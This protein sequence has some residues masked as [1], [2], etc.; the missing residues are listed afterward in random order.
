MSLQELTIK[1][2]GSEGIRKEI[3]ANSIDIIFDVL[4]VYQYKYPI[5][6]TVRE[7]ASNAVDAQREKE[8]A[9]QILK[10]EANEEDF[11]IKKDGKEFED[12]KF[13]KEYYDL[14]WLD[15]DNNLVELNYIDG[16]GS[17]FCDKFTVTDY[18]VGIGD[19]RLE[20][21]IQLGYSTK[22]A[23]REQIGGFG[24]GGK[25]PLSTL[26]PFFT[27]ESAYNGNL[28]KLNIYSKKVEDLIGE[29]DF[30]LD[31]PNDFVTLSNG[32]KI[33]YEHTDKK[34]YTKITVPV[35]KLNKHKFIDAVESQLLY[36]PG[37][38][39][40]I[41]SESGVKTERHFAADILYQSENIIISNNSRFSRPHLIVVKDKS[42]NYGICYNEINY[43]E[44]ELEQRHGHVGLKVLARSVIT[45]NDGN[46][47]VLNNGVTIAPSRE[48]VVWN[49]NTKEYLLDITKRVTEE[50][51][52]IISK[53][54]VEPDF[55]KWLTKCN[56][57]MGSFRYGSSLYEL[58]QM[59]DK[60]NIKP[61]YV[62]D[63]DIKYKP[64]GETLW[65]LYA[66]NVYWT[67][68]YSSSAGKYIEKLDRKPA[69]NWAYFTN[70][71]VYVKTS[72]TPANNIKDQYIISKL[73]ELKVSGIGVHTDQFILLE[74]DDIDK[75]RDKLLE[76]ATEDQIDDLNAKFDKK[77]D[78]LN[79][80]VKHIEASCLYFDYD[81]VVVPEDFKA[82]AEEEEEK[83][84][85]I[86]EADTRSLEELRKING[87][88]L[89]YV[90]RRQHDYNIRRD[91]L[92]W[93]KQIENISDIPS[94]KGDVYYGF[95]KD[96]EQIQAICKMMG[97]EKSDWFNNK[98]KIVKISE[99]NE[100][101]FRCVGRHVSNFMYSISGRTIIMNEIIVKYFTSKYIVTQLF[102]N[103][104]YRFLKNY[105]RIDSRI[106]DL[107]N[108]LE[109]YVKP[110][111]S[112]YKLRY[113]FG[114]EYETE[115]LETVRKYQEFQLYV[116][117]NKDDSKAI[118]DK[119]KELFGND[120]IQNIVM[121]DINIVKIV[122]LI[123][124]YCN[125]IITLFP[126]IGYFRDEN[127]IENM[128]NEAEAIIRNILVHFGLDSFAIPAEFLQNNNEKNVAD[129]E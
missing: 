7:L 77:V 101:H 109:E 4:Q 97:A 61:A 1:E 102:D 44:L 76:G 48:Y 10:G 52:E 17:G 13:K 91:V 34:N 24:A 58:S 98:I 108:I 104:R 88:V 118:S 31:K 68:K 113:D 115:L 75:K 87:E 69:D 6:S 90:A 62:S 114:N 8:I 79:R 120:L 86:E 95:Q 123:Q 54:L 121:L 5:E 23:T 53:E 71:A 112:T 49:D 96:A 39:F 16:D 100:K 99:K 126:E 74:F 127:S 117:E 80:I 73:N 82:K 56:T 129:E 93:H 20:G 42:S 14:Q 70:R 18:G 116:F 30:E 25:S 111:Y 78:R 64:I 9:I 36:L 19:G 125:P 63:K 45:D 46:E 92:I 26:T 83:I 43:K 107:F 67:S 59:I 35:K 33:Y 84:T 27:V 106:T 38:K 29:Y 65:G 15:T 3:N 81:A 41:V 119:A 47:T 122:S 28:F 60:S 37:I 22:R 32:S 94:W 124:E 89:Y 40:Y 51:S 11:F 50:S 72:D 103:G 12:S 105:G 2:R 85:K 128:P 57:V 66:R 21:F 55:L 110:F